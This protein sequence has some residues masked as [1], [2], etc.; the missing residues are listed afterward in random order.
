M[1]ARAF[2]KVVPARRLVL[3]VVALAL[4]LSLVTLP[5]RAQQ[6][7]PA[8]IRIDFATYNPVSLVLKQKGW[9]EEEFK[10]DRVRITWLFSAGS[11]KAVEYIATGAGDFTSSAGAA[12]LLARANRVPLTGVYIYSKPEWTA[13]VVRRDSP[14]KSIADL[15]GKKIAATKGTDPYLF[16]LRA[17]HT[18]G[19]TKND[20]QIFNLQHPDGR[21]ALERGD[22]DAWAGLDPHMAST[23][24]QAGSRLIYR[25]PAFNT[26]GF[27]NVRDRFAEQ[28][29]DAVERVLRVYERARRWVVANPDETAQILAS[30]A[31]IP[32]DVARLE[33][34]R[35]DFS[36]PVPGDEQR[37]ALA[38][39]SGIL[40]AEQLVAPGADVPAAVA[41]VIDGRF[42][43]EVVGK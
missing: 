18:A 7:L 25:N 20:V 12:A 15:R 23:E 26:Y 6:K 13:V 32:L 11:N 29:P 40:V 16:L 22:V 2:G 4:I 30:D 35:N 24:L 9:L 38:A 34:T 10:S 21:V 14:I 28:Y 42:A 8:E 27:L 37:K 1:M 43:R 19:L 39:A 33:L 41:Q 17:L 36:N 5:V 31:K 3:P